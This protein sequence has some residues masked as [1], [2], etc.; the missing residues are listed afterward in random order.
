MMLGMGAAPGVRACR[1]TFLGRPLF[2]HSASRQYSPSPRE[3]H[4]EHGRLLSH[5]VWDSLH[6]AHARLTLGRLVGGAAGCVPFDSAVEDD[7]DE[8]DEDEDEDD[9][10][11]EEEGS[12]P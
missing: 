6:S 11:V 5:A 9:D 3:T 2:L 8:D 7:E 10:E 12:L 4:R 1:F